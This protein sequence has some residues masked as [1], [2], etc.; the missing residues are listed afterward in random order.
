MGYAHWA[1]AANDN[2]QQTALEQRALE[3][4]RFNDVSAKDLLSACVNVLQ[5]MDFSIDDT[6]AELGTITASKS[7]APDDPL[8]L[9]EGK[10]WMSI[11][12]IGPLALLSAAFEAHRSYV[13]NFKQDYRASLVVKA[14]PTSAAPEAL[15]GKSKNS[16]KSETTTEATKLS[17]AHSFIVRV[18]F[19]KTTKLDNSQAPTEEAPTAAY[20]ETIQDPELYQSFYS[21]LS[22]SVFI[23]AEQL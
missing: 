8:G 15:P 17:D 14:V 21:K 4:R 7:W 23:E 19:E 2:Q 1:L 5:D 9:R 16:R 3:S 13:K 10:S 20:S 18:I 12:G 6:N 22:K 11:P